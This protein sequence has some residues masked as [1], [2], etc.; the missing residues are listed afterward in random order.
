MR[1]VAIL[2]LGDYRHITMIS[3]YTAYFDN[4][5]IEYDIICTNRY[6]NSIPREKVVSLDIYEQQN[7]RLLKYASFIKFR[8]WAIERT[9]NGNYDFIVVWNENTALLFWDYLVS[10]YSTRY[11]INI[12]DVD[13]L[14]QRILNI[15][16][17][18]AIERSLFSTYCSTTK[19]DF[20]SGYRY[21]IMRSVNVSILKECP[22]RTALRMINEP[23]RIVYLGKVRFFEANRKIIEAFGNDNRYEIWFIGVGSEKMKTV[24]QLY[25]NVYL[26]GSYEPEETARYL[27][28]ADVIDSYFGESVLGYERM[29]S[30]R[31]MYAPYLR[32]PVIVGMN[33]NMEYEASEYGFAYS[34]NDS[35]G[36]ETADSFYKWYHSLSFKDFAERCDSFCNKI[37]QS[38]FEFYEMLDRTFQNYCS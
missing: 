32:I 6:M 30:I 10:K 35:C 33:T 7:S 26:K 23:I 19:L 31:Y 36:K 17:K 29:S 24:A 28:N 21:I 18:I 15:F 20:P 12:R 16:R 14:N 13:F 37:E 9:D 1:K 2:S 5:N 4:R 27:E 22:K 3:K 25:N 34:F 38:E 11:C 8:N